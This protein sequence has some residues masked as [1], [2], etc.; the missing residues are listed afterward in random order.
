[1][2]VIVNDCWW[3]LM[4]RLFC[5]LQ[6]EQDRCAWWLL[7]SI[8]IFDDCWWWLLMIVDDCWLL[9][10][11]DC[12]CWDDSTHCGQSW[13]CAVESKIKQDL[14][15]CAWWSQLSFLRIVLHS[16][17][18]KVMTCKDLFDLIQS[19]SDGFAFTWELEMALADCSI[20]AKT[21][22]SIMMISHLKTA[23]LNVPS[24]W[25]S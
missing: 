13:T 14:F 2:I 3:L 15:G 4:L 18:L 12:W 11:N 5:T 8:M 1:M 21:E 20:D 10:M 22:Y 6:P 24:L 23:H 25:P 9:L 17:N 16:F 19:N 7:L